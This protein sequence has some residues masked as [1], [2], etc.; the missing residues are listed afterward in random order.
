M[1]LMCDLIGAFHFGFYPKTSEQV[2]NSNVIFPKKK[3]MMP[4][5]ENELLNL[6]L[7]GFS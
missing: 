1:I 6:P 2:N 5:K 7:A 3:K 4:G